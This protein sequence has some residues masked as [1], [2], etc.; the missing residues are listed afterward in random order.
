[1]KRPLLFAAVQFAA[2]VVC[3]IGEVS[4]GIRIIALLIGVSLTLGMALGWNL[5]HGRFNL[6]PGTYRQVASRNNKLKATVFIFIFFLGFARA[7]IESRHYN[8]PECVDFFKKYGATNPGQFDFS[9]YLKSL[10][11]DSYEKYEAYYGENEDGNQDI[12][13][14][15]RT[16][17]G[18]VLD[19]KLDEKDA[20]LYRAILMGD[21][22]LLEDNV[23]ELYRAAGISHLLAVSGLHVGI[24]GSGITLI[25]RKI[26]RLGK[27]GSSIISAIF[28]LLYMYICGLQSS[29]I[30]ASVMLIMSILAAC[31]NKDYDMKTAM[32]LS[33]IIIVFY[34]PYRILTS[35]LQ[36]SFSAIIAITLATDVIEG[37]ERGRQL[38]L[39]RKTR[40]FYKRL[41]WESIGKEKALKNITFEGKDHQVNESI[42]LKRLINKPVMLGFIKPAN[43]LG[44]VTK[45]LI[46]SFIVQLVMLPVLAWHFYTVPLYSIFINLIVIPLMGTVVYS[47]LAVLIFSGLGDLAS[48]IVGKL[49]R[50]GALAG[51]KTIN[52]GTAA[53]IGTFSGTGIAGISTSCTGVLAGIKSAS[54]SGT[55]RHALSLIS[56]ITGLLD[57]AASLAVAPGHYILRLYEKLS[58]FISSLPHSTIVTGKPE[59]FQIIIYYALLLALLSLFIHLTYVMRHLRDDGHAALGVCAAFLALVINAAALRH[60]ETERFYITVLDCGQGDGFV[61][62][63]GKTVM[64]IDCGS[65]SNKN[66]GGKVLEPFLLSK[67]IETVDAAFVSHADNDH[68]SGIE[69]ILNE[70][71]LI[72]VKC[73]FLPAAAKGDERYDKLI[74]GKK[75]GQ[76]EDKGPSE[77]KGQ[78]EDKEQPWKQEKPEDQGLNVRYLRDKAL[79]YEDENMKLSCIYAGNG[80][81][82]DTNRHSSVLLLEYGDVERSDV[83]HDVAEFDDAGHGNAEHRDMWHGNAN[84]S[85]MERGDA[86]RGDGFY[87]LFTGDASVE[88]E[89]RIAELYNEYTA[90]R[91]RMLI[92]KA[93]HHGSKTSTSDNFLDNVG[94]DLAIIS[95]GRN[96]YGHPSEKVINSL[97]KRNIPI[98]STYKNGCIIIKGNV[99]SQGR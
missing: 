26:F 53:K 91:D 39:E 59:M 12:A 29:V 81:T 2:G 97:E 40:K 48:S 6:D 92:L 82:S 1:M 16:Y 41:Y 36:L 11:I 83:E 14:M 22:S 86:E 43:H 72:D 46:M 54:T 19:E 63:S 37:M 4:S 10:G 60:Y 69:Y 70:A 55:G 96:N 21:K 49:V 32:A 64:T 27:K 28:I 47:G 66:L 18:G 75:L 42:R 50:T 13:S 33:L 34:R 17:F 61:I 78:S 23:S 73:L 52:A 5:P 25:L 87:M 51:I 9:I 85:D 38:G 56:G 45:T 31:F 68:T 67:G 95:Y 94:P 65:S 99:I 3:G 57:K 88:D 71:R 98:L 89:E 80:Q 20:G 90:G 58:E 79:V 76:S 84:H 44:P 30:R 74:Q 15:A 35:G 7:E 77:D 93:A 8:S 24:I 62:K